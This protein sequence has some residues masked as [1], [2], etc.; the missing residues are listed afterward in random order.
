MTKKAANISHL[1]T[2]S[3]VAEADQL[4]FSLVQKQYDHRLKCPNLLAPERKFVTKDC[5]TP[6]LIVQ[7]ELERSIFIIRIARDGIYMIS[8][9]A[10]C[11]LV[12]GSLT[13]NASSA[14]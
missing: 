6:D 4:L 2:N 14:Q 13:F 1:T 8:E 11:A 7:H 9:H 5:D 12:P 10:Y 3:G